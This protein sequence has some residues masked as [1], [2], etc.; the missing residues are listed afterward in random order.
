MSEQKDFR[1]RLYVSSDDEK[2]REMAMRMQ[3]LLEENFA[4]VHLDVKDIFKNGNSL[5][6]SDDGVYTIPSLVRKLPEPIKQ[7]VGDLENAGA[8]LVLLHNMA[9][10]ESAEE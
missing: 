7:I 6:A 4:N 3:A 10:D 8:M 2:T 1:F 9:E 5:D